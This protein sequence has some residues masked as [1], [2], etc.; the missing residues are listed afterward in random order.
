MNR[1]KAKPLEFRNYNGTWVE[2]NSPDFSDD[3]SNYRIK[4][5]PTYRPFES[6]AEFEPHR[7]RWIQR[8]NE[9]GE[10]I[11]GAFKANGYDDSGIWLRDDHI[12][13][14]EARQIYKVFADGTPFGVKVE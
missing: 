14:S 10:P 12:S 2:E 3:P 6:S 4:P 5:E 9:G 13:Y 1:E 11:D 8:V 7:D